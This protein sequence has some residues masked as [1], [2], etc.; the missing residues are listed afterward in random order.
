MTQ[1]I[2]QRLKAEREERRLTLEKVFEGTRIRVQYLQALEADDL[3]VMPSPV[4][5]RGYL[6]NYAEY[7]GLDVDQM[8]AELRATR[9]QPAPTEV[10]GPA[11]ET[12]ASPQQ[13]QK[14]LETPPAPPAVEASKAVEEGPVPAAEP[15]SSP[16]M[17]VPIKPKPARRKKTDSP[18]GPVADAP[19]ATYAE[20]TTRRRGRKKAD[21]ESEV[22]PA[23]ES[24]PSTAEEI[25]P[26]VEPVPQPESAEGPP[27][28]V[29]AAPEPVAEETIEVQPAAPQPADARDGRWLAWLNRVRSRSIA[30]KKYQPPVRNESLVAENE[31]LEPVVASSEPELP[32]TELPETEIQNRPPESSS[33]ILKEIGLQLR[34]RRELLSL[35][36]D[37]V[38]HNTHVKAYYLNALEKGAL[39]ELPSTVQTRGM[40]SNYATFLDLDVDALLLRFADA[41][42]ARHRER[43]PQKLA[44]KPGQPIISNMPPFRSFIAGDMIFGVG[45]A[46]LLVGFAIW[47][48]SRVMA[49]QS[50]REVKPTAPSISDMLLSTPDPSAFTATPTFLPVESFPGEATVTVEIP[51][52]NVNARVQLNLIAVE[53]TYM[54][55]LVDGKAVFDGRVV[56]GN[57]YPFEAEN[58]VEVLVGSGAAIRVVYNGRDLGLMGTFG[59]VLHNI[60]SGTEITTPTALPTVTPTITLTP[61]NTAP[62]TATSRFTST[63]V[64]SATSVP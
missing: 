1:T 43:N 56:P 61:T 20:P 33:E 21:P 19:H 16:G 18:P 28:S 62:P 17:T 53:R 59:Q 22:V 38:E 23:A 41:L 63:P 12:S 29:E 46:V 24:Q 37:E 55:V 7:L 3:S 15:A 10:I 4:Q 2:G 60:Y 26:L 8:L 5:A 11:D 54:R 13:D 52:Q 58:Q 27:A 34:D 35:H 45:M 40:L 14:P 25:H 44:R 50:Q 64:P 39:D 32:E 48:V 47:G 31:P 49:V 9:T 51:T 6:R 30:R 57:A 36:L 42:Q